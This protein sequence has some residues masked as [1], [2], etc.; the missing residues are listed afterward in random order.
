MTNF[1]KYLKIGKKAIKPV[2]KKLPFI[3]PAIDAFTGNLPD[4]TRDWVDYGIDNLDF[5]GLLELMKLNHVGKGEGDFKLDENGNPLYGY[6]QK[7]LDNILTVMRPTDLIKFNYNVEKNNKEGNKKAQ[8]ILNTYGQYSENTDAKGSIMSN[9]YRND[10]S[11]FENPINNDNYSFMSDRSW[12]TADNEMKYNAALAK[13]E[14]HDIIEPEKNKVYENIDKY[15]PTIL[16]AIPGVGDAIKLYDKAFKE[17][18]TDEQTDEQPEQKL[19]PN[20]E[21]FQFMENLTPKYL[22]E[23]EAEEE[24]VEINQLLKNTQMITDNDSVWD[25]KK[26]GKNYFTRRKANSDQDWISPTGVPLKAIKGLFPKASNGRKLL[27]LEDG[28]S[29]DWLQYL[30]PKENVAEQ[31]TTIPEVEEEEDSGFFDKLD[32]FGNKALA[33]QLKD[34]N[35]LERVEGRKPF[36]PAAAS[37]YIKYY[38]NALAQGYGLVKDDESLFE[39]DKSNTNDYEKNNMRQIIKRSIVAGRNGKIDY[40]D[41][42]TNP[43][44][45]D[46]PT[47]DAA[48]LR[49]NKEGVKDLVFGDEGDKSIM[50]LI[51]NG[52][53]YINENGELI[54]GDNYDFNTSQTDKNLQPGIKFG[55]LFDIARGKTGKNPKY[56]KAQID[57][58]KNK[59][60]SAV[61]K[62]FHT[63]GDSV[64]STMPVNINLGNPSD[65]LSEEAIKNLPKYKEFKNQSSDIG[66]KG[67]RQNL[68]DKFNLFNEEEYKKNATKSRISGGAKGDPWEY[69]QENGNYYTRKKGSSKWISPKNKNVLTS[70]SKQFKKQG[71]SIMNPNTK[72]SKLKKYIDGG[73]ITVDG[74][75]IKYDDDYSQSFIKKFNLNSENTKIPLDQLERM[76]A[77]SALGY[78]AN[79]GLEKKHG[80]NSLKELQESM[81]NEVESNNDP[82]NTLTKV[83]RLK[84]ISQNYSRKNS[85]FAIPKANYN[86]YYT[87][88]Q[89]AQIEHY[90]NILRKQDISSVEGSGS[91]SEAMGY[92]NLTSP[93]YNNL[94]ESKAVDAA[95]EA[96]G[97]EN[98]R[99]F[100]EYGFR[101]DPESNS[102][103]LFKKG[104]SQVGVNQYKGNKQ[105]PTNAKGGILNSSKF[106]YNPRMVNGGRLRKMVTGGG[107]DGEP[108]LTLDEF[109]NLVDSYGAIFQT[110]EEIAAARVNSIPQTSQTGQEF[111]NPHSEAVVGGQPI[112]DREPSTQQS[113]VNDGLQTQQPIS[114]RQM[115]ESEAGDPYQ[116]SFLDDNYYTRKG[117]NSEWT[118]STGTGLDAIKTRYSGQVQPGINIENIDKGVYGSGDELT[119]GKTDLEVITDKGDG[120]VSD[121]KVT[122]DVSEGSGLGSDL[123]S[124]GIAALPGLFAMNQGRK[125]KDT[126]AFEYKPKLADIKINPVQNLVTPDNSISYT[127]PGSAD[128]YA[129]NN[130]NLFKHTSANSDAKI[131]EATNEQSKM[132]QRQVN[133]QM[134]NQDETSDT[135]AINQAKAH[136]SK[137]GFEGNVRGVDME[138]K[139]LT[140]LANT[141]YKSILQ[142]KG[143]SNAGQISY[144]EQLMKSGD[145]ANMEEAKKIYEK[146]GQT[147]WQKFR[148]R[149]A[150]P[151][152]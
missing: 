108:E 81:R 146:L 45:K 80:A 97:L 65:F 39:I 19:D 150:T 50:Y 109:G 121:D 78:F 138:N 95:L 47:S 125:L 52:Q 93:W 13:A 22:K 119:T 53:A 152:T 41:Y 141:G 64:K 89:I 25:Y 75:Q 37:S 5:V 145:P 122:T 101:Y 62:Y 128:T 58:L 15:A 135:L 27:N 131:Q 117:E 6:S 100:R 91:D 114:E 40:R 112:V 107:T 7:Q 16:R 60:A 73:D 59:D 76:K 4:N 61:N 30:R 79:Y 69:K 105:L 110:A 151:V 104:N 120:Y 12:R 140:A 94:K 68:K 96:P 139:G 118:Q 123:L 11:D 99:L 43:D 38:A 83:Q 129:G 44:I 88:E 143:I 21:A 85:N 63:I 148:N 115:F 33:D 142:N 51:G 87:P 10:F 90:Q 49:L 32:L 23:K 144:A 26:E 113:I 77:K 35:N 132:Q 56:V 102:H 66:F 28:G 147:P 8:E 116:Y 84:N 127:R 24:D 103:S 55:E 106:S 82:E 14:G 137:L 2:A 18:Q 124:A 20:G 149:S 29:F 48:R 92:R 17:K 34:P 111:S 133:T 86:K 36:I 70:I 54:V 46:A 74:N 72:F 126:S 9:L 67:V 57:A 3:I 134:F 42:S 71:G 31:E 98:K 1:S 130:A 136:N